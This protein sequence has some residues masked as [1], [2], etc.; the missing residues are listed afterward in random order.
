MMAL[1]KRER[2]DTPGDP[3]APLLTRMTTTARPVAEAWWMPG[4]WTGTG[5]HLAG[6]TPGDMVDDEALE[7][8]IGSS[9]G[10]FD[11]VMTELPEL[12]K[13]TAIRGGKRDEKWFAMIMGYAADV[14]PLALADAW[15]DAGIGLPME[16]VKF[17]A[18]LYAHP[19]SCCWPTAADVY[20]VHGIVAGTVSCDCPD[21][22]VAR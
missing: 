11:I 19:V 8:I 5:C 14:L 15:E 3:L 20:H 4:V 18:G 7:T 17:I 9:G 6:V 1:R 12:I 13:A 2:Q 22:V 16:H 10:A 21:C